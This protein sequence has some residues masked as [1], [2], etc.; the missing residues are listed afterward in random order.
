MSNLKCRFCHDKRKNANSLR[1]HE[2]LCKSNPDK[3]STP[4]QSIEFQQNR[5]P[6]NQ[7]I[8]GKEIGEPYQISDH[9][10]E[11]LSNANKKRTKEWHKK[12]GE[13]ISKTINEKVKNGEWHTSLT[14]NMHYSYKGYD[15]HGKWEL[16]Y[17]KYLDK[18]NIK[19]TRPKDRFE[20]ELDGKKRYYT[21]DF[22]LIEEDVFVEIKGYKTAKDEAKWSQ[23]NY[24]TS[25]RILMKSD[26]KQL[27]I[28]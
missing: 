26:L 18:N 10:R 11:K 5:K 3:Q 12:N 22:Y 8:K 14:K 19:W 23:F 7:W 9:T 6:S 20:Y 17:A 2:R 13:K 1:N 4:F 25:L 24:N 28:I 15:L 27:E 16:A 21:P